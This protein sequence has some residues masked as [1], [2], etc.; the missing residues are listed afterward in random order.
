[1]ARRRPITRRTTSKQYGWACQAQ[2]ENI[3]LDAVDNAVLVAGD[4]D[5]EV[6]AIGGTHCNLKRIIGDIYM[7]PWHIATTS[8]LT[9]AYTASVMEIAWAIMAIDNDDDF[10]QY[11]PDNPTVLSEERVLAHGLLGATLMH[12]GPQD[13]PAI[14]GHTHTHVDVRSNRRIRSDDD[15]VLNYIMRGNTP[16]EQ[17]FFDTTRVAINFRCLLKFPG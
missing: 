5:V 2:T 14:I 4:A 12:A 13:S 17:N 3:T 16:D 1:M 10:T 9:S 6:R 8:D 15:I 7:H 11:A